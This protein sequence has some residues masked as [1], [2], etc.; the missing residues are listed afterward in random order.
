MIERRYVGGSCPNIAC[1]PSK[2]FV[3]SAKAASHVSNSEQFGIHKTGFSVDMRGV[4]ERKRKMVEGLVQM[5][6]NFYKSSGTELI[7]GTGT[8][9][10][11]TTISVQLNE[12]GSRVVSGKQVVICVGTRAVIS[13]IP[14][15]AE[16]RPMTHIEALELDVVPRHLLILGAGFVG[17]E[18][19]QAMR[20]FGSEVTVLDRNDRVLHGEDEDI[21]E[22]LEQLFAAEGIHIIKGS[23]I[24]AVEGL[25]SESVNIRYMKDGAENTIE[26]SHILASTGRTPN[27]TGIGL[28]KAGVELSPAGFIKVNERM[29]TSV[30]NVWAVGD[31][32]GSPQFT[33]IAFDDFRIVRENMAGRTRTSTGRQVPFCLFTDPEFARVGL[34]ETEAKTR[35]IPHRVVKIPITRVLRAHTYSE[36]RGFFK[37]ILGEASDQILGFS[38][39]GPEV[40]DVLGTIQMAMIAGLPYTAVRDAVLTHPTM[41]EGLGVLFSTVPPRKP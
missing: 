7:F 30:P 12:G 29:Q 39:F 20:R 33:H 41:V 4:R 37:A 15:L 5:H 13:P 1:L 25:S 22:G 2:N 17:M 34:T 10:G 27:T 19:A 23:K 24:L 40:A 3:N 26:G 11:P 28:E 21:S 32:A 31:C 14:G 35:N 36:S 9:I 16:A 8:F 38:A 18:F 6:L